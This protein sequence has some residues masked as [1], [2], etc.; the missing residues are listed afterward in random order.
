MRILILSKRQY[1]GK[2]LL[3]DKYGRIYEIPEVLAK[4]G[5]DVRGLT[6]S[7]RQ[8]PQGMISPGSVQWHSINLA[9]FF[10]GYLKSLANAL[11]TFR[12]DIVIASSDAI[13]SMTAWRYCSKRNIPYVIDLYDNYEGFGLSRITGVVPMLRAACRSAKGITVVGNALK[14][15]V[16]RNYEP[17]GPVQV[18]TNAIPSGVFFPRPKVD[19]RALLD[20][21]L[22]GRIIGTAG[23]ISDKRGSG[24]MFEAFLKLAETRPDVWLV[25]AGPRDGTPQRY[26]H[27]RI[28][29]LGVL[30]YSVI[31]KLFNALDVG[32]ICNENSMFGRFCFPQKFY[33]MASCGIPFVA[34]DVGEMSQLLA[35]RPDCLYPVG[36]SQVLAKRIDAHLQ[37]PAPVEMAAI[38][39][40][41]EAGLAM[42]EFIGELV[43]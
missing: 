16:E 30:D 35:H 38:P 27:Q 15:Y 29:D 22:H 24:A 21:P 14:S 11:D 20:L 34:T 4:R 13:H 26:K 7:Y 17:R 19:A 18:I 32:V 36:N 23:S 40:W 2:D 31:P 3:D 12:P 25:F 1:T 33:E 37:N 42:E 10:P 9:S 39:T 5:H 43:K 41:D 6:L 28:I 8:R